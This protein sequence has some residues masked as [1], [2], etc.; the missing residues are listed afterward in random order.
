MR[1]SLKLSC[2][3]IAVF[4]LASFPSCGAHEG[5]ETSQT[6]SAAHTE[7]AVQGAAGVPDGVYGPESYSF[8]WSGGSGKA[9]ITCREVRVTDGA[10]AAVLVFGSEYYTQVRIEEDIYGK[11]SLEE[12]ASLEEPAGHGD[13]GS[14]EEGGEEFR[15]E[16][17][18]A[19]SEV[20]AFKI[21]VVLNSQMTIFATTERMSQPHEI[22]YTIYIAF[23]SASGGEVIASSGS[24]GSAGGGHSSNGDGNAA[25]VD[26]GSAGE[27]GLDSPGLTAREIVEASAAG[28]RFDPR[29]LA[30]LTYE[31]T[32][33][34]L[35]AEGFSIHRYA[36]GY[37]VLDIVGEKPFLI[38]PE[39][40]EIPEV[41]VVSGDSVSGGSSASQ[42][43][44]NR[45]AVSGDLASAADTAG[46]VKSGVSAS[47]ADTAGYVKSG[48]S[49]SAADEVGSVTSGASGNTEITV[50]RRPLRNIYVAATSVMS[51]IHAVG[52]DPSVTMSGLRESGWTLDWMVDAM[53][54]GNIRYAGSY[55]YP[56]YEML[57]SAGCPLAVESTMIYHSPKT[58]EKLES[59]G[60]PVLVDRSS[61]E[62]EPLARTEWI[63]VY[64]LLLGKEQEAVRVLDQQA[65]LLEGLDKM[66]PTGKSIAFFTV[67]RDGSMTVRS[68]E[69]Y[70]SS[71]IRVAG[72]SCAFDAAAGGRSVNSPT[73]KISTESFFAMAASA[74][75]LVYYATISDDVSDMNELLR[76]CPQL[77]ELDA[78]KKG[79]VWVCDNLFYQSTDK[80]AEMILD[81]Y[82]IMTGDGGTGV[83]LRKLA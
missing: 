2:I 74:D 42:A 24:G 81:F 29:S 46:Y 57:L 27:E 77:A 65:G 22:E 79:N 64:G 72:G 71:M 41:H 78:V 10:A 30:G 50:V 48:I 68:P 75:C 43:N 51:L 14:P 16:G 59:L 82:R 26:G 76:T 49:A 3:V 69:D 66:P 32:D 8:S 28:K 6:A 17:T 38:V 73:L 63:R 80:I 18:S 40:T 33:K 44:Y 31:S 45:Q 5:N 15:N 12:A 35:C 60:I 37:A 9:N 61:Y 47:A 53:R 52:G 13:G 19:D 4:L 54:S 58:L 62:K 20:S 67:N 39:G 56:D 25:A 83:F 23:D 55:R 21:P 7:T 11:L 34:L 1:F 70:I 36:G